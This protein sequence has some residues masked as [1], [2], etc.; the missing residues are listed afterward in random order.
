[1]NKLVYFEQSDSITDTIEREKYLNGK[2]RAFKINL[3]NSTNPKWDDLY[4]QIIGCHVEQS[5]TSQGPPSQCDSSG[6]PQN[7]GCTRF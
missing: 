2:K 7:D 1:L 5:E 6:K 3:I 4:Q